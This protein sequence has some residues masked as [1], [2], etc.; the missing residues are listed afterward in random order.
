MHSW[1][2]CTCAATSRGNARVG[3]G[4][5]AHFPR[6]KNSHRSVTDFMSRKPL[7]LQIQ[8]FLEHS[9]LLNHAETD[10]I[11]VEKKTLNCVSI[12]SAH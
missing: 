7:S 4:C 2:S 1:R 5:A 3:S 9:S 10:L 6:K 11:H 12:E 8:P